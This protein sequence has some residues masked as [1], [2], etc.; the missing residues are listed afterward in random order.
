MA[1]HPERPAV[2][3]AEIKKLEAEAAFLDARRRSQE[4]VIEN[5]LEERADI[6][7]SNEEHGIYIFYQPI[8]QTSAGV[9][10]QT[11]GHWARREDRAPQPFTIEFCSP[12]GDVIAGFALIDYVHQLRDRGHE[13]NTLGLGWVA[14]MAAICLQAGQTR[15]MSEN[16]YMLI[17]EIA[18]GAIGSLSEIED[19]T[20]F[21]KRLN[22]RGNKILAARSHLDEREIAKKAKRKDW[23]LDAEEALEYGFIDEVR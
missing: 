20:K 1:T 11:L 3:V 23:W 10:I 15:T 7:A 13:I 22:E 21:L 19:E 2:D 4:L 14:S 17:H 18:S 16:S 5:Q 6:A 9:C 8:N 12:G